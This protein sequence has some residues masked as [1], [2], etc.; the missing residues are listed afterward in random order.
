MNLTRQNKPNYRYLACY[1]ILFIS[2]GKYAEIFFFFQ[3]NETSGIGVVFEFSTVRHIKGTPEMW[4]SKRKT[5]F[6]F[7]KQ[8]VMFKTIFGN[9]VSVSKSN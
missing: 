3:N 8:H 2:C 7:S 9:I 5:I 1:D 4:S 6:L